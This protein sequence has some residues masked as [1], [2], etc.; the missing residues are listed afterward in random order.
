MGFS[1][2][3]RI[4][5]KLETWTADAQ[6]AD[7]SAN[8]ITFEACDDSSV[9]CKQLLDKDLKKGAK[10]IFTMSENFNQCSTDPEKKHFFMST[11]SGDGWHATKSSIVCRLNGFLKVG[12]GRERRL[13]LSCDQGMKDYIFE[14]SFTYIS[15]YY[16]SRYPNFSSSKK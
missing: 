9:C 4:V 16:L 5:L 8:A 11:T 7:T 12:T 14:H 13:P 15:K 1:G 2:A 3:K 10:D 6:W